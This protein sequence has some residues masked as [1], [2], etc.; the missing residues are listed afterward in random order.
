MCEHE[1]VFDNICCK[2]GIY[3]SESGVTLDLNESYSRS[4]FRSKNQKDIGFLKDLKTKKFLHEDVKTWIFEQIES[5]PDFKKKIKS[6]NE[7]LYAYAYQGYLALGIEFDPIKLAENLSI[8][9]ADARI[10]IKLSA[11]IATRSLPESTNGLMRSPLDV[12]DPKFY[13][14]EALNL[15]DKIDLLEKLTEFSDLMISKNS[16]LLEERPNKI[17]MGLINFYLIL[18]SID[19]TKIHKKFLMTPKMLKEYTSAVEKTYN[20]TT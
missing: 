9:K 5:T 6:K 7:T 4:H 11:G 12:R 18:N 13:L 14:E 17:A 1:D 19:N 10:G 20:S 3:M 2:C 16:L 15:I 8:N